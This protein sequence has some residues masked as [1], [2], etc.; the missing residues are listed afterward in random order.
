MAF[1]NFELSDNDKKVSLFHDIGSIELEEKDGKTI[2]LV[3]NA[4]YTGKFKHH[5]GRFEL[6]ETH[7]D[8][9]IK[10]FESKAYGIEPAINYN[11]E[12]FDKASGWPVRLYKTVS[13]VKLSDKDKPKKRA[14][15]NMEIEW[16]P[17]AA[18]AIREKEFRY[19]SIEFQFEFT[20]SETQ[21]KHQNVVTGGALTNKPF[22]K[23]TNVELEEKVYKEK[24]GMNK[25]EM[26]IALE[27]EH[28]INVK[29]LQSDSKKLT[30]V[31][32]KLS[33]TECRLKALSEEIQ[34]E[35][36]KAEAEKVEVLL[37]ELL[38]EGKTTKA[39]NDGLY[40]EMFLQIGEAKAR[41]KSK[42]LPVIVKLEATGSSF[43]ESEGS[44]SLE[45]KVY[46]RS[47]YL[48]NEKNISFEE[49]STIASNEIYGGVLS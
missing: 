44:I 43:N 47:L 5:S 12:V 16:T 29:A 28:D 6:T 37:T 39:L 3:E 7:I 32:K 26:L 27:S 2:G 31:Q 17:A 1:Q 18:K 11:H 36:E 25:Q 34:I 45:E 48:E 20:N 19:F 40:R 22:L 4:V 24:K 8:E 14:N 10:N 41:E 13:E 42:D 23:G 21:E 49:A 9:F 30:E 38:K 46:N 15:L 35:R 33:E